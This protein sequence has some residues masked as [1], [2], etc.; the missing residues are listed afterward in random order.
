MEL[1][2]TVIST[3]LQGD[4]A[5]Y[6]MFFLGQCL[7]I[8]KRAAMAIRSKTNPI[9]SRRDFVTTNWDILT[10]RIILE[11]P[12]YF[13]W[14]HY[15]MAQIMTWFHLTMTFPF[16][17]GSSQGG[18]FA[19]FILGFASDTIADWISTSDS[20]PGW[21]KGWIKEQIPEVPTYNAPA[22]PPVSPETIKKLENWTDMKG[23]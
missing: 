9:K 8:L 7:Y 22:V 4:L 13:I 1:F 16:L 15:T 23:K 2:L 19:Y 14:R 21:L 18:P 6:L 17:N 12:I 20:I 5:Y 10:I 3:H 11:F